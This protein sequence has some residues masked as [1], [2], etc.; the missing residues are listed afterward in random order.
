MLLDPER[1]KFLFLAAADFGSRGERASYLQRECGSDT[2]LRARVEALLAADDAAAPLPENHGADASASE[3]LNETIAGEGSQESSSASILLPAQS[4]VVGREI[5]HGGMG[6]VL[7]AQDCKLGREVAMKVMRLS[8]AA[9]EEARSRFVREATVLARLEHPNIVPIHELGWDAEN[10]LYYTMKLVQGRTLQAVLNGLRSRDADFIN[11]YTLDRLLT[12]FRKICDAMSLAHAKGVI[13]RDLKPDN[14]MVGEFGEVLVMDWGLARIQAD[15][16]QA[17]EEAAMKAEATKPGSAQRFAELAGSELRHSA[18]LTLDGAVM[19]T[20][21]YMSPEQAGGRLAE[22]DQQSDIFSLGGILYALLTLHPPVDGKTAA[23]IIGRI[24]GGQILPPTVYNVA[25]KSGSTTGRR[26]DE[27]ADPK[28]FQPLPHCP[29]GSVPSALSAVTMRALGVD[30]AKR[31]KTVAEF[32][33]DIE[34]YQGGFATSAEQA[35]LLTQL[36]LLIQRHKREFGVAFAAWLVITA[37]AVWFVINLHASERETRRQAEIARQNENKAVASEQ[38]A[39]D[40]ATRAT[41][42]ERVARNQAIRATAAEQSARASEAEALREKETAR[43]ALAR[44]ALSLAEAAQREGNG[45]EMQAALSEVPEDLR[46]STWNYLLEQSDT[47]IARIPNS[48]SARIEDAAADPRRPGVFAVIESNNNVALIDVHAGTRLFEFAAS[49]A[50]ATHG[51]WP[52]RTIAFSPDG[53]RI[54]VSRYFEDNHIA[55]HSALDGKKLLEWDAPGAERLEFSPDGTLLLQEETGSMHLS[56][57]NASDGKLAWDYTPTNNRGHARGAFTADSAQVVTWD[58]NEQFQVVNASDGKLIRGFKPNRY[59]YGVIVGSSGLVAGRGPTGFVTIY[60]LRTGQVVSEFR[61]ADKGGFLVGFAPG[62]EQIVTAVL[63]PDGRQ[64]LTVWQA[65]TG[66]RLRSLL[67]GSGDIVAM[68]IHP[69]TRELLVCGPNTRAWNLAGKPP[70]WEF[71]AISHGVTPLFWGSDDLLFVSGN[72]ANCGL[73]KLEAGGCKLLWKPAGLDAGYG[74]NTSVAADGNVA[75]ATGARAGVPGHPPGIL[76]L[77]NPGANPEQVLNELPTGPNFVRLSP[78]GDR[79]AVS[80]AWKVALYEAG[81]DKEPIKLEPPAGVY[82]FWDAGWL[83]DGKELVGLVTARAARGVAGAEERIVVWDAAS[84][85]ILRSA[86][87]RTA[88]GVLAVDPAGKRLAEAGDDKMVRIRDAR[89]LAVQREF[90]AHDGPITAMA[91]HPSKPIL[92]T[93][94]ADLTVKLWNLETGRR[95]EEFHVPPP[96]VAGLSFSPGGKRLASYVTEENNRIWEPQSL[97]DR[98]AATQPDAWEDLLAALTPAM[99]EQTGNGWRMDDGALFS[100]EKNHAALPLS[101]NFAATSY[102]LHV[103]LRQLTPKEAFLLQ[104]PVGNRMVGFVLDGFPKDGNYTGL[105][106]VNGKAGKDLSGAVHGKVVKDSE[107]HELDVTVKLFGA[108]AII[109]ATLDG[110]P[111]YEWSGLAAA[112][113]AAY[114]ATPGV[115]IVGTWAGGWVVYDVKAKRQ[116]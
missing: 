8:A 88:L 25:S 16:Q 89:T 84:G 53:Q 45:P 78:R 18:G 102:Q 101:G 74:L 63:L 106:H 35:G 26:E 50:Q 81:A 59:E 42:A 47:S 112:L 80:M 43:Q 75:V 9:S 71:H 48:P 115:I 103:K 51:H 67:G 39:K 107:Q 60:D 110:Q 2:E 98:P 6:S 20:P 64:A 55:I 113:T 4:Y 33:A 49:V 99:V 40:E 70:T 30:K 24:K 14:I 82:R 76:W 97:N 87:N 109:S 104:F 83:A 5:A 116:K 69:L 65:R 44:S 66:E 100:P 7:H 41:D 1:A 92:A 17:A 22:I 34:A 85:K 37:L 32:A 72:G 111:L 96:G 12:I 15:A 93:A 95:L 19:G 36:R 86:P 46:D 31:Y 10:R 38:T 77:R 21:L 27:A 105:V 58:Q 52:R 91:W 23:E 61:A 114:P 29:H 94:S 13:H 62:G 11:H 56:V 108:H 54:A 79:A 68:G 28:K 73:Q 90:R 3:N 57:W